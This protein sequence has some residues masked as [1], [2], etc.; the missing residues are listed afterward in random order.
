MSAPPTFPVKI[1]I[2]KLNRPNYHAKYRAHIEGK[3]F[4]HHGEGRTPAKALVLAAV[5][6][7]NHEG[8]AQ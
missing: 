8:A 5:H 1:V 6:W 2:E 7:L 3:D 4:Y